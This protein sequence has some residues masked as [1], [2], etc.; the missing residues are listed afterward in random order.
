[1]AVLALGRAAK[2]A[3]EYDEAEARF[4]EAL[5]E[6]RSVGNA[7]LTAMTLVETA[8][9]ARHRGELGRAAELAAAAEALVRDFGDTRLVADIEMIRA[10]MALDRGEWEGA[11][12][13]YSGVLARE[14]ASGSRRFA[15]SALEG[16]AS[17]VAGLGRA[18]EALRLAGA[19][20]AE[21]EALQWPSA[22]CDRPPLERALGAAR[23]ALGEPAAVSAFDEGRRAGFDDAAARVLS[24]ADDA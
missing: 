4:G 2:Y 5:A 24:P 17:A 14:H 7:R 19:A 18:A 10:T 3:C 8:E 23:A 16:V 11:L 13:L 12:S 1:M 15:V 6:F 22:P 9:L 20:A 21:R